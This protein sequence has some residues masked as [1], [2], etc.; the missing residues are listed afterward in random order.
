[1]STRCTIKDDRD[2]N[3]FTS[4]TWTKTPLVLPSMCFFCGE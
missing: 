2:E 1:M 3:G 4:K